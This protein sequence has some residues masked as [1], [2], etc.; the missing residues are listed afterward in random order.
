MSFPYMVVVCVCVGGGGGGGAFSLDSRALVH[1]IH[2]A[3][4]LT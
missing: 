1:P 3:A 2:K 4:V